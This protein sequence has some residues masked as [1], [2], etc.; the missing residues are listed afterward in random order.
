MDADDEGG[1]PTPEGAG[2]GSVVRAVGN[3]TDIGVA[4]G[5]AAVRAGVQAGLGIGRATSE[6]VGGAVEHSPIGTAA[7]AAADALEPTAQRVRQ[8]RARQMAEVGAVVE[9]V[10][11]QVV[12]QVVQVID[13][14][15]IVQD[16]D[17][18][19]IVQGIDIDAI[20][21]GIDIE[22]IVQQIDINGIVDEIDIDQIVSTTEIGSLVVQSTGGVATEALDVVRSQGVSLDG[23]VTRVTDRLVR[24]NEG[25][26]PDAPELLAVS[27][28]RRPSGRRSAVERRVDVSRKKA[29]EDSLEGNYAGAAT[30]LAAYAADSFFMVTTYG[31]VL[32]VV[33]FVFN[34]IV[35]N[36]DVTAPAQSTLPYIVGLVIWIFLYNGV[37]WAL[38]WKTPGMSL[39][40]LRVVE[41]DGSD[42]RART[43]FRRAFWWQRAS[44]CPSPRSAS[45]SGGSGG[46]CTTCS[47]GPPWSTTGTP[48][49]PAGG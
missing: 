8:D 40:G 44:S 20:V 33:V 29:A 23:V 30:R 7:A 10:V 15:G 48:V 25:P 28:G 14:N 39:L 24:R 1:A 36:D 37:C 22:G 43:G 2:R 45:S 27:R 31:F 19:H 12:D 21:Q 49:T 18:D 26:R 35:R 46:P 4:Y 38:W 34:L 13:I 6:I 9:Q 47:P 42:L 3:A 32:A 17:I 5:L 11:G 16:V 41:R